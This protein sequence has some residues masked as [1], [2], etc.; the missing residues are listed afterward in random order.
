MEVSEMN[1]M[2]SKLIFEEHHPLQRDSIY[3]L[4]IDVLVPSFVNMMVAGCFPQK[5]EV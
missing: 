2:E 3:Y 1:P 5:V 4:L